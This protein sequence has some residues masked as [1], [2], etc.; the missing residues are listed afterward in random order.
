[1]VTAASVAKSLGYSAPEIHYS[2]KSDMYSYGIVSTF[3]RHGE[4][5]KKTYTGCPGDCI[6]ERAE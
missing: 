6:F 2:P 3:M 1:M 5:K 4:N